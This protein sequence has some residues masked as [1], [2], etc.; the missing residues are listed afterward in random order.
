MFYLTIV[1]KTRRHCHSWLAGQFVLAWLS[2]PKFKVNY[3]YW[4]KLL[5][6]YHWYFH[7]PYS[8]LSFFTLFDCLLVLM[9]Y[10]T[11][12]TILIM[13]GRIPAFLGSTSI[14]QWINS[15]AHGQNTVNPVALCLCLAKFQSEFLSSTNW[16]T[17][18]RESFCSSFLPDLLDCLH[19]DRFSARISTPTKLGATHLPN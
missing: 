14:N 12:N 3:S 17:V 7:H 5:S 2:G 16:A 6:W 18:L 11:V 15:P 1:N 19:M 8:S 9:L 4:T 13:F 10:N